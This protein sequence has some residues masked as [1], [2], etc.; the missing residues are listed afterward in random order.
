MRIYKLLV[1]AGAA[2]M[3]G[4][5]A[6]AA[7]LPA[8]ATFAG[9]QNGN[10]VWSAICVTNDPN[11]G[12]QQ[13][14]TASPSQSNLTCPG[15]A[16][17]PQ[18]PP[19]PYNHYLP[20]TAGQ[21]DSMP[22]F[23]ADGKT[24]YFSSFRGSENAIYSVAFPNTVVGNPPG[25]VPAGTVNGCASYSDN[26]IQFT[27]LPAQT[28]SGFDYAPTVSADGSVLAWIR[29][30]AASSAA[31]DLWTE[32]LS[33]G[34][35]SSQPQRIASIPSNNV[36]PPNNGSGDGDGNRP[37]IN[38][39]FPDRILYVD[40]H[41]HVHVASISGTNLFGGSSP[42]VDLSAIAGCP[43]CATGST[44]AGQTPGDEHPDWSPDGSTILFD[45]SRPGY[46]TGTTSNTNQGS[47]NI[48]FT[49]SGYTTPAPQDAAL[50]GAIPSADTGYSFIEAVYAPADGCFT[51]AACGAA[52]T[53]AWVAVKKGSNIIVE[54]QTLGNPTQVFVTNNHTNNAQVTWQPLF[55]SSQL[56][57][58]PLAV[59]LPIAAGAILVSAGLW[60][61]RRHRHKAAI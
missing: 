37:E 46:A 51:R 56:P 11:G 43:T 58:A 60:S 40:V 19:S 36:A 52:P 55:S 47:N 3:S 5:L 35:P 31:C 10:L 20:V 42:D 44:G 53:A 33:G 41:S 24:V 32:Q 6:T 34:S 39:N 30:A 4:G 57:E 23:S 54:D 29:C 48:P 61:R 14:W 25:C 21:P 27:D 38:P 2:M 50:W 18:N 28:S 26:A 59:G 13:L 22:Y 16:E 45:S 17:T 12:G 7:P 15:T 49:M 9:Q 8:G 1:A